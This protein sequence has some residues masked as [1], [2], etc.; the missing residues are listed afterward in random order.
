MYVVLQH[1]FDIKDNNHEYIPGDIYPRGGYAPDNNRIL[2]L[3]GSN[4]KLKMP[5]IAEDK[6]EDRQ[7]KQPDT[8]TYPADPAAQPDPEPEKTED[9]QEKPEKPKKSAK[10]DK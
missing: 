3:S 5:L 10:K 2:E 1:F 9:V 8:E 7:K 6:S 4:N